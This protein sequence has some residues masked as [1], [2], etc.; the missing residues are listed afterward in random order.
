MNKIFFLLIILLLSSC[1]NIQE[2]KLNFKATQ[3]LWALMN[4]HAVFENYNK[5][6]SDSKDKIIQQQFTSKNFIFDYVIPNDSVYI[7]GSDSLGIRYTNKIAEIY[8]QNCFVSFSCEDRIHKTIICEFEHTRR[9]DFSF[10][11]RYFAHSLF[12]SDISMYIEKKINNYNFI[13]TYTIL[14]NKLK[15]IN[16]KKLKCCMENMFIALF[17]D[18]KQK[19]LI[20]SIENVAVSIYSGNLFVPKFLTNLIIRER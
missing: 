13:F 2:E 3:E 19:Y 8:D 10:F 1:S 16:N 6:N 20:I 11:V 5:N 17:N 15:D 9:D 7:F 14:K 4:N 18:I 12:H